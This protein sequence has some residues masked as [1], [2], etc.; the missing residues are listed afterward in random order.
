MCWWSA[1]APVVIDA[2]GDADVAVRCGAPAPK[3]PCEPTQAASVMF[4]LAGVSKAEFMAAVRADPQTYQ[5]WSIREWTVETDGKEDDMFSA[6]LK[7]PFA[8]AIAE[9]I[10]P[11]TPQHHRWHLGRDA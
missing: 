8:R 11:K 6:I 9:G 10:I 7:K 5:D 4:H 3:T 2:M 1:L